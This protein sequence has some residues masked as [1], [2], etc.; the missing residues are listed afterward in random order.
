MGVPIDEAKGN[1]KKITPLSISISRGHFELAKYLIEKEATLSPLL[2]YLT[3]KYNNVEFF[4]YLLDKLKGQFK[5]ASFDEL[6]NGKYEQSE[7][8]LL[9]R[10]AYNG[11]IDLLK[12]LID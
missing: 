2:L 12:Y 8:T 5:D 1:Q 6:V 3:C 9:I 4:V 7:S 10:A 11:S